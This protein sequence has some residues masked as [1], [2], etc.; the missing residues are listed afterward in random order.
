[1]RT[2][3]NVNVPI[4]TSGHFV[5]REFYSNSFDA[6]D[7]HPLDER[8]ITFAEIVR[9]RY[10]AVR[11]NSTYRTPLGN[12]ST[13]GAA[14]SSQHVLGKA[15]DLRPVD[16]QKFAQFREDMAER[17]DVFDELREAGLGGLGFYNT[18]I[19][20]DCRYITGDVA[21]WSM[22]GR[23]ILERFRGVLGKDEPG[24]SVADIR[25]SVSQATGVP[26]PWVGIAV[27][28]ILLVVGY[29]ILR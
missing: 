19:H 2:I 24:D 18:F 8:L 10:G 22:M 25:A 17:R 27:V 1:M 7:E 4:G 11:I 12:A 14:S 13:P 26:G 21:A 6:P 3:R 20:L 16:E 29:R 9:A 28:F 23:S 15:I 5:E